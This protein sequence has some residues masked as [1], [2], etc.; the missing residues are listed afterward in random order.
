LEDLLIFPF[1]GN[2]IEA[3]DALGDKFNLLGFVDDSK[4]GQH[5]F[6]TPVFGREAFGRFK[7]AKVLSVPGSSNS[8]K[9]RKNL[10]DSLGI[11]FERFANV[12]HPMAHVSKYATL[13][14]NVL[15]L[16]GSSINATAQIGNNVIVLNNS[17][18]HH[19]SH[20]KD[21]VILGSAVVIAGNVVVEENCYIG[22][23]SSIINNI[24]IGEGALVG[25]GSNVIKSVPKDSKYVGN[26]AK[27]II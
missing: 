12:I 21:N 3:L 20:L 2:A 11:E 7:T 25:I 26:P 4:Q 24:T 17:I 16:A 18:V 22:S 23:A 13:G 19:D 6:G 15:I 5:F 14:S 27:Q 10:I 8:Y 9:F 1:N